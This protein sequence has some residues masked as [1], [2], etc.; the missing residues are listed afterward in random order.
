MNEEATEVTL[1]VIDV[2]DQL[3]I[4]YLI[5]GSLASSLYGFARTTQ[6]SDLVAQIVSD[7]VRSLVEKLEREFYV[8]DE[9]IRNAIR[10]RGSF[11]VI[12]FETVFKVDV[13]LPKQRVFDELQFEHRRKLVIARNPD[14]EAYVASPEDIV[15]AKLEWYKIG[16]G[17]S[18][19]Q[20]LDVLGILRLQGDSL[21]HE[22]LLKAA[23]QL[24]VHDLLVEALEAVTAP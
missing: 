17:V 4:R 1:A 3:G 5:T 23:G 19:R 18:E 10:N 15:L 6:D 8:S 11:N 12:H 24:N 22:Y 16:N 14:Q 9:S 2:L 20:W 13:F 21:D 7:H